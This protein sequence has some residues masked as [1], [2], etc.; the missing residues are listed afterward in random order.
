MTDEF[1]A[2]IYLKSLKILYNVCQK[3]F[4]RF[5]QT[6]WKILDDQHLTN[7]IFNF[8]QF[9]SSHFCF[10]F[11]LQLSLQVFEMT[12]AIRHRFTKPMSA[13]DMRKHN[14]QEFPRF[15]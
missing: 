4:S 11:S 6:N 8:F 1:A 12:A 3:H 14:C 2:K 7:H 13:M 9:F 10:Y 15:V 5:L